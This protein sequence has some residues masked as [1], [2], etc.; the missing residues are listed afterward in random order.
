MQQKSYLFKE[1]LFGTFLV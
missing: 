1:N